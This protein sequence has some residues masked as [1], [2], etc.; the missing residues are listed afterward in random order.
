MRTALTIQSIDAP[1]ASNEELVSR[2]PSV[3]RMGNIAYLQD[4]LRP[5]IPVK[6]SAIYRRRLSGPTRG[7]QSSPTW[8]DR[9]PKACNCVS[10]VKHQRQIGLPATGWRHYQGGLQS[11][12]PGCW[13]ARQRMYPAAAGRKASNPHR[14]RLYPRVG[15]DPSKRHRHIGSPQVDCGR[16]PPSTTRSAGRAKGGAIRP[17]HIQDGPSRCGLAGVADAS[18]TSSCPADRARWLW[19]AAQEPAR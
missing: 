10:G 12:Q 16:L 8:P 14:Q 19:S 3:S 1:S 11:L 9:R 13:F 7:C 5:A 15:S 2:A 6:S 17:P 18:G 4:A